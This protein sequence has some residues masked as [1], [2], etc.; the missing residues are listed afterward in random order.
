MTKMWNSL[1][2]EVVRGSNRS[3][4]PR[5]KARVEAT[6][7]GNRWSFKVFLLAPPSL[8]LP[9][10]VP[11]HWEVRF[12][13]TAEEGKKARENEQ[14]NAGVRR[15]GAKGQCATNTPPPP[16]LTGWHCVP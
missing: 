11:Y 5:A 14:P 2:I 15:K 4:P 12:S 7:H 9:R 1:R 16:A 6:W 10:P 3:P 8:S 13:T